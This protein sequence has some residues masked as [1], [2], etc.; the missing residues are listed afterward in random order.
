MPGF[1]WLADAQGSVKFVNKSWIDFTGL[2]LAQSVGK[3]WLRALH[4]DDRE[5]FESVAALTNDT[6]N[7][8]LALYEVDIRCRKFDGTYHWQLL[9]A[10]PASQIDGH[11]IGCTTN[12]HERVMMQKKDRAQIAILSMIASSEPLE[13]VLEALCELGEEQVPGCRSS[14]L[15]LDETGT[16][17]QT[18]AAPFLPQDL[19]DLLSGTKIGRGVGSCGTAAYEKRDIVSADISSDPLWKDWHAHFTLLGVRSCWSRPVFASDGSVLAAFGF[20]FFEERIPSDKEL[21]NLE[22]LSHFAALAIEKARTAQALR[23]SEEHH[24]HTVEHNPQ[25]PWTADPQGRL[26]NVS[27]R[28]SE[29]TGLSR[30]SARGN[31]WLKALHPDDVAPTINYWSQKL[32]TGEDVDIKYRIRLHDGTY[33]W[34]RARAAP[35]RDTDGSIIRWYGTVEDIQELE[36]ATK[37]LRKQVVEDDVTRVLN[38]RGLEEALE[39]R[40]EPTS[41]GPVPVGLLI[42]DIDGFT[43]INNR[44]GHEAG[45]ATLRLFGKLLRNCMDTEDV[46]ARIAGDEFAVLFKESIAAADLER[47]SQKLAKELNRRL[48]RSLKTRNCTCR[49]GCAVSVSAD[50]AHD[51]VRR[52]NM[53]LHAAKK[54]ARGSVRLFTPQIRVAVDSGIEQIDLAKNALK[55]NWIVPYYQPTVLLETGAVAGAEALL[56]IAHPMEGTLSPAAIWAAL[57]APKISRSINERMLALVLSDLSSLRPWPSALGSISVNLSTDMLLHASFAKTILRKLDRKAIAPQQLTVEITERVLVD[58][59]SPNSH[60]ALSELQDHGVRISLDDFGTGFASLTHLQ[61]L[62][63]NEIKIDRSFIERIADKGAN[64]AIV[65]SMISLGTNMGVDVVAEGVETAKQAKLLRA[66]GCKLAQGFHFY[67]P[68]PQEEFSRLHGNSLGE[69]FEKVGRAPHAAGLQINQ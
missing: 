7:D 65:K 16:K 8:H 27:A 43:H 25:I 11:W 62:P 12:I 23:E 66:W 61:D 54:D 17:F 56:R 26:L 3:G 4:P 48:A 29:T 35:R 69:P 44:F 15:T 6:W 10:K 59:L 22:I 28:W 55:A 37:R 9:R 45:D 32:R 13:K 58:D 42:V 33:R 39:E 50:N 68:M 5:M 14:V 64:T 63:V 47:R 60:R 40:L 30:Q 20:Y 57:D 19:R 67:K 18:C 2:S 31:G 46:V 34:V 52:A 53:A 38:R 1:V 21:E 49:I 51:L 36:L 24:R 41:R